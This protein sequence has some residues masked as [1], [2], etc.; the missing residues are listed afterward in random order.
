M[1]NVNAESRKKFLTARWEFIM[2]GAAL[3]HVLVYVVYASK[4]WANAYITF[5]PSC[6]HNPSYDG[7]F[8]L[9]YVLC[10]FNEHHLKLII[11]TFCFQ[12]M[13]WGTPR[14]TFWFL[15]FCVLTLSITSRASSHKSP[16]L[17]TGE[18]YPSLWW[19][20]RQTKF[21]KTCQLQGWDRYLLVINLK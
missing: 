18:T 12:P 19:E 6:P 10:V 14:L 4:M 20:T 5:L 8:I 13:V 2:E 9:F 1:E 3:P 17:G 11:F 21:T 15:T 7:L 16:R